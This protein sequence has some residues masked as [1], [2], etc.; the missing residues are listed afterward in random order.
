MSTKAIHG[1][2]PAMIWV[3]FAG[4]SRLHMGLS[5]VDAGDG[6]ELDEVDETGDVDDS[7]VTSCCPA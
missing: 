4:P 7:D 1:S 5:E 3:S 2:S 6:D